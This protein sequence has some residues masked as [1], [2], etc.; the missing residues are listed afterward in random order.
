MKEIETITSRLEHG[1]SVSEVNA[2]YEAHEFP[3][4]E[5]TEA[6]MAMLK[7]VER[8]GKSAV[9]NQVLTEEC[10]GKKDV[11]L[12]DIG[13][14]ALMTTLSSETYKTEEVVTSFQPEDF[15]NDVVK[16][17]Y[18]DL[19][20]MTRKISTAQ[21]KAMLTEAYLSNNASYTTIPFVAI[22]GSFSAAA[23]NGA[24]LPF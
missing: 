17:K 23:L 9:V 14:K 2:A 11:N 15:S 4:L 20:D 18:A 7:A 6:Q 24:S 10:E 3:E 16:E 22:F 19:V 8:I 21:V 1:A 13:F 5:S 12:T